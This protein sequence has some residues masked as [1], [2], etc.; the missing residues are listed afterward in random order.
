MN[1]T[2]I[3]QKMLTVRRLK[4][5]VHPGIFATTHRPFVCLDRPFVGGR[6][7]RPDFI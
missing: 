5:T 1:I 3:V 4:P 2:P 6:L 7:T